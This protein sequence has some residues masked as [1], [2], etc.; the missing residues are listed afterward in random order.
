MRFIGKQALKLYLCIQIQIKN[1][2]GGEKV[3]V[4]LFH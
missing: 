4:T 1:V 3:D 2:S